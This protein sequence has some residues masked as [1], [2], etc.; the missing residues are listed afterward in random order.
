MAWQ[1]WAVL[2]AYVALLTAGSVT[3]LLR[4][5]VLSLVFFALWVAGLSALLI[6]ICWIQG[7][8]PRWR[9]GDDD[10]P[11]EPVGAVESVK[12]VEPD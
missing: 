7:E 2:A 10:S 11:D 8:R 6:A 12:P 5:S 4:E 3:L 1:G 9:W